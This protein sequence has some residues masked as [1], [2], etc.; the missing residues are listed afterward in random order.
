MDEG[1]M[2][3]SCGWTRMSPILRA[4]APGGTASISSTERLRMLAGI[5]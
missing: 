1:S 5:N 4:V 2:N 3:S